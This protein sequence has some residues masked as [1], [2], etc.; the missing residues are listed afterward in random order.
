MPSDDLPLHFQK[1][2]NMLQQWRWSGQ[3]YEK[4]SNAWL[5]NMDN[6]RDVIW[7]LLQQTYD[8]HETQTWWMRWRI[9]F[10]AC[11]E[12]FA[13]KQGQEWYVSHYLFS[14]GS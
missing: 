3:H 5:Q 2:M 14:K 11:A 9:F 13:Y 4:T 7:P 10:M 1:D 6:N 8:E 12:L